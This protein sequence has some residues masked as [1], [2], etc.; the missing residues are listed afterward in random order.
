LIVG[1]SVGLLGIKEAGA[2][3][4]LLGVQVSSEMKIRDRTG[5]TFQ[6][7]STSLE[8][9]ATVEQNV[10]ICTVNMTKMM[11]HGAIGANKSI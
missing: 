2:G 7:A 10:G 8:A 4:P 5:T 3:L 9:D 1:V 11:V 6:N